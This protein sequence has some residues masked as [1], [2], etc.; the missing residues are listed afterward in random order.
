MTTADLF[1]W[2]PY[3]HGETPLAPDTF[4]LIH[5]DLAIKG[6]PPHPLKPVAK[7]VV[8]L[9]LKDHV[10]VFIFEAIRS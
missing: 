5:L 9:R 4:K 6:P 3:P 1:T 2:N 8:R 7:W 10:S